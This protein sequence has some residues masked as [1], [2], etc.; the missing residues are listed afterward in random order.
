[1]R[2][3]GDGAV[4]R[5]LARLLIC[6]RCKV[7]LQLFVCA[8]IILSFFDALQTCQLYGAEGQEKGA[9]LLLQQQEGKENMRLGC[10]VC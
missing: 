3:S 5:K 10:V 9:A 1:M 4:Q 6:V 8:Q 7:N 2:C